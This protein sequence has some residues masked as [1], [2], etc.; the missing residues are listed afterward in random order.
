MHQRLVMKRLVMKRLGR[1]RTLAWMLAAGAPW[2]L[3]AACSTT[4]SG[5]YPVGSHQVSTLEEERFVKRAY[6]DLTGAQPSA[7]ELSSAT[8]ALHE[9]DN[10]V[11]ARASLAHELVT[12]PAFAANYVAELE[13]RA[14]AGQ[15]LED[16]FA[17]FC[18]AIGDGDAAC[19]SCTFD[20]DDPCDCDCEAVKELDDERTAFMSAADDLATTTTPAAI[21]KRFAI[22]QIFQLN[23]GSGEGIASGLFETFLERPAEPDEVKNVRAMFLAT[24]VQGMGGLLFHRIGHDYGE[25][26]DIVFAS[27]PFRDASVSAVFERY[28]GRPPTPIEL[29]HFSAELDDDDPD[30]RPVIEAVVSSGEY[31]SQ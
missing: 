13:N 22:S 26:I 4:D 28:L 11:A 12:R 2:C 5:L 21:E 16:V 7:D 23:G 15:G 3:A 27:E 25:L 18:P 10:A 31:F 9:S 30:V 14:F 1:K 20:G 17:L 29:S 19:A 6:L 8:L 24:Q